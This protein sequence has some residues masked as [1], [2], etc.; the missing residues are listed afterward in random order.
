MSIS[1]SVIGEC[2]L[3]LSRADFPTQGASQPMVMGYGGDTLNTSIYLSRNGI[4]TSYVTAL[5]DDIMSDWL[6]QQWQQY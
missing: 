2:M 4:S 5:G 3:E 1:I 6:L